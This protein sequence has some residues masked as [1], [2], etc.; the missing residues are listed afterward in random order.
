M[1][2]Y[3]AEETGKRTKRSSPSRLPSDYLAAVVYYDR[4]R[5]LVE[6]APRKLNRAG[7][8][9]FTYFRRLFPA[10]PRIKKVGISHGN[11]M[12]LSYRRGAAF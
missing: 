3:D 1:C 4:C 7:D 8:G 2:L 5:M 9:R 12:V 6:V 11:S 10:G